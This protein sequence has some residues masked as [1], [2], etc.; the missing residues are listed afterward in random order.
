[1]LAHASRHRRSWLIFDVRQIVIR[2][3]ENPKDRVLIYAAKAAALS[4][5][6]S[7]LVTVVA[8][9]VLPDIGEQPRELTDPALAAVSMAVFAPAIETLLMIPIFTFIR[10]GVS[11]PRAVAAYSA[12][13]WAGLHSLIWPYWGL[14]VLFPFFVFSTCFLAWE[15]RSRWHAVA[16]TFFVH[17]LHNLLPATAILYAPR[18]NA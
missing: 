5:G 1:V 2:S 12:L 14:S 8:L 13:L 18:P 15:K 7:V 10:C 6:V 3:L 9:L 4:V 11:S 17:S 16:I